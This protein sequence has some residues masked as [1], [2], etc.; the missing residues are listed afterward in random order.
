MHDGIYLRRKGRTIHVPMRDLTGRHLTIYGQQEVV[1]DLIALWLERGGRL[2]FEVAG[3]AVHDLDSDTPVDQLGRRRARVRL[4]RRLRRVPRDLPAGDPR[5][6]AHRARVRLPLRLARDP[7]SRRADDG[8]AHLRLARERLRAVLDALARAS[9]GSTSRSRPT[10]T[11]TSGR[12]SA[13]GRS[14]RSGSAPTAGASARAR[15]SRRAS[16][17]CAA[18]SPSRCSTAGCTS[19][20]TRLT[21]SLRPG[22]RDSTSRSTTCACSP[23]PWS[24]TTSGTTTSSCRPTPAT[25]CVASGARRTSPTT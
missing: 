1:K 24:R 15:S 4:H 8:R 23:T 22:R 11:S 10:R 18:S 19:P 14:C 17:R 3:T 12:T 16:P 9:A 25:R 7:R 6:R 20:A 13:S 5:G 2:E 21:S